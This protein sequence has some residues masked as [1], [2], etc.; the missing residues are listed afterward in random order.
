MKKLIRSV[1]VG[2]ML[3]LL[4]ACLNP[5][6]FDT[7]PQETTPVLTEVPGEEPDEL[8][9]E[10]FEV[11][12]RLGEQGGRAVAGF[13]YNQIGPGLNLLN[14]S[15]VLV[16]DST[17]KVVSFLVDRKLNAAQTG[18]DF[19]LT[20]ISN[21][22]TTYTFLVLMGHWERADYTAVSGDYVYKN[23]PPTLLAAGFVTQKPA[24]QIPVSM[25]QIRV[26]T[27][28]ESTSGSPNVRGAVP[29][30]VVAL[31]PVDWTVTWTLQGQGFTNL[32]T[33]EGKTPGTATI[34]DVF[35]AVSD[36][37]QF[38]T[39]D[40]SGTPV[41]GGAGAWT[42]S[43]A[44]S[45]YTVMGNIGQ[46]GYTNFNVKYVP[47]AGKTWTGIN[48]DG[49]PD[50]GKDSGKPLWILRNGINDAKQDGDTT[51]V[52]NDWAGG[53][54]G[55]GAVVFTVA[56]GTGSTLEITD[57]SFQDSD[58]IQFTTGGYTGVANVYYAEVATG[59]AAP[60]WG[61]A[62]TSHPLGAKGPGTHTVDEAAIDAS[63]DVYVILVKD[64]NLST[65]VKL[66]KDSV[67]ILNWSGSGYSVYKA[68]YVASTGNDSS[69]DGSKAK[70]YK[71]VE[72]AL[73]AIKTAYAGSTWPSKGTASEEYGAVIVLNTV[74]VTEPITITGTSG[75]TKEYPAI[76]LSGDPDS[77][78]GKLLASTGTG[79]SWGLI[80]GTPLL[81]LTEGAEV[82]LVN[83][84]TLEGPGNGSSVK[85]GGV[86]LLNS[87][88]E[89][90]DALITKFPAFGVYV[91]ESGV[92]SM[93]G[94][95]VTNN[96][97]SG[98]YLNSHGI[99][100]MSGGTISYNQGYNP[101][102]TSSQGGGVCVT[103]GEFTMSSSAVIEYNTALSQGG[104]V[105]VLDKFTMQGGSIS[106]N[107]A[108]KDSSSATSTGRGGGVAMI[109]M[110]QFIM[111]GGTI[112]S[113]T[114]E[115]FGGGV[116]LSGQT[117]N[118]FTK[119]G[120][121]IYGSDDARANTA[122]AATYGHAIAVDGSYYSLPSEY[123]DS[124]VGPADILHFQD[125]G[126]SGW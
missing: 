84:L 97:G 3:S 41:P 95:T 40:I 22:D 117:N 82:V 78:G 101:A 14:Y 46:S 70:P 8:S 85:L 92:A 64:G 59:G 105:F 79:S 120:G 7:E 83:G 32:V 93:T 113:N 1:G 62:Y 30:G 111:E 69:G 48:L 74:N 27:V 125:P 80:F 114:A 71:T 123:K 50:G 52:A 39:V 25:A 91:H 61:S 34:G 66:A 5:V 23:V 77:T 43:K 11:T 89:I 55:N 109:N 75:G 42:L 31:P 45:A 28:F 20:G 49:I 2:I 102:G 13:N 86:D 4:V 60:A 87:K 36:K 72:K 118:V 12:L 58:T 68:W 94:G 122:K 76:L 88:L 37:S 96:K 119:T 54:N 44:L 100:N 6:V 38:D 53:K 108:L 29:G 67:I 16:L 112:E 65:P 90:A 63:K 116:Y 81:E 24:A 103:S 21:W 9:F 26:D 106:H 107:T 73:T 10:P 33:A 47:F 104:G 121:T 35:G 57:A 51:F 15:Q 124:T 18:V 99:F 110:G 115:D 17:G 56:M 98:V 19:L 126:T